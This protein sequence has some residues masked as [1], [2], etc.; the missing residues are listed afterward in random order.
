M[1]ESIFAVVLIAAIGIAGITIAVPHLQQVSAD[2]DQKVKDWGGERTGF[3]AICDK[4]DDSCKEFKQE[5]G[6]NV[7]KFARE[8]CESDN[9]AK[10][11][12]V[13]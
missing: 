8:G 2:P 13:K 4:S 10:C 7:N 5:N 12:Q 9:N 6:A 11:K 3:I 1:R